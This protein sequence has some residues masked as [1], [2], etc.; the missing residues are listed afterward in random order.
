[1]E[2]DILYVR[3][4]R[5]VISKIKFLTNGIKIEGSLLSSISLDYGPIW[6]I[7]FIERSIYISASGDEG[8]IVQVDFK[9]KSSTRVLKNG[10]DEVKRV[11]GLCA[12]HDN[13]LIFSDRDGRQIKCFDVC[14]KSVQL[15]AGSGKAGF[16]DGSETTAS[17]SQPTSICCEKGGLSVFVV[18]SGTQRIRLI[19]SAV[20]LTNMLQYLRMFLSSF[21][22]TSNQRVVSLEDTISAV[23]EYFS[24][25]EQS[26][27]VVQTINQTQRKTQ[28]PDG[29]ISHQTLESIRMILTGLNEV[30]DNIV[31]VNRSYLPLINAKSLVSLFVENLF[32]KMRGG[33]TATPMVYD[34]ALHFNRATKETLKSVTDTGFNYLTNEKASYYLRPKV[35]HFSIKYAELPKMP[36]PAAG[37]LPANQVTQMRNWVALHGKSV[38]QLTTR[39]TSTKDKAGTLPVNL[40]D[41]P[42]P[43]EVLLDFNSI[44][45][46]TQTNANNDASK[47]EISIP[48]GSF[49]AVPRCF[50]QPGLPE[51]TFYLVKIV[52]DITDTTDEQVHVKGE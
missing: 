6:G 45:E 3:D 15:V 44:C 38:R 36:K 43:K 9:S 49:V 16:T 22:V 35:D 50:R 14:N 24:Y 21:N 34:F 41:T 25:Q 1:M 28:G 40:Y 17:F 30:K 46:R 42:K 48:K 20:A 8:G 33:Q 26:C 19:T 31:S 4:F 7:S 10:T 2:K 12:R 27:L 23:Q 39:N 32:E 18:D 37:N 29:T 51:S 11:H 13:K 5:G 52:N 47:A